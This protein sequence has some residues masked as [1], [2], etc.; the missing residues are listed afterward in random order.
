[1]LPVTE[2][3]WLPTLCMAGVILLFSVTDDISCS[4]FHQFLNNCEILLADYIK[5]HRFQLLK[6]SI[7]NLFNVPIHVNQGLPYKM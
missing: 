3:G 1:M 2:T 6:T 4:L 7:R 5:H